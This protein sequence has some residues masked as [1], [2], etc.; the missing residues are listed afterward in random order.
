MGKS[1]VIYRATTFSREIKG[2]TIRLKSASGNRV[3]A[4]SPEKMAVTSGLI[5][6]PE[7][8]SLHGR[9]Q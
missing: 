5:P 3:Y 2:G 9:W 1:H 6:D 4:V 7:S 8:L